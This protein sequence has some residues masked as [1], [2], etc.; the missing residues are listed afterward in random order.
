MYVYRTDTGGWLI[1]PTKIQAGEQDSNAE[2]PTLPPIADSAPETDQ[3]PKTRRRP[4][5]F[6]HFLLILLLFIGLDT[7]DSVSAE[8][9]PTANVTITPVV[10]TVT[11]STAFPI[12]KGPGEVEGRVLPAVTL[13]Q[14]Q[15]VVATGKGHQDAKAATGTLTFYNGQ[16]QSITVA[17]G[18]LFTGRDGVQ[19]VTEHT[20]V[21]PAAD[22]S[23]NPPAYGYASVSAQAELKGAHGNIAALDLSGPCCA[24]SVIVKNLAPFAG[25]QD[26]RDFTYVQSSDIREA[27]SVLTTTLLR[28]EQGALGGQL[29]QG[30]TLVTPQC[31]A[32]AI[33]SHKSGDE[34]A[35]AQVTVS[36]TCK[37]VAYNQQSL[38]Q[39]AA[40]LVRGRFPNPT[41]HFQLAGTIQITVRSVSMQ[42]GMPTL[43]TTLRGT[44]VFQINVRQIQSL[45]AGKP[46][47]KAIPILSR[48]AGVQTVSITGIA[49][50]QQLPTDAAHIHLNIYYL[51]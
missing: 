34:A 10:K 6:L 12:G 42:N 31:T 28:G 41:M 18:T 4:P 2:D 44:F 45:V 27:T 17:S 16:L 40:Q 26:A 35:N 46:I 39:A 30:E 20:A 14:S 51:V 22:A 32:S 25:G 21:I 3:R 38:Q 36:E 5:Y 43:K 1:S 13:S 11:T 19:I 24:G 49:D 48:L 47:L 9:A 15:T 37:A 23:T 50:N 33:S 29:Q 8:F 7:V